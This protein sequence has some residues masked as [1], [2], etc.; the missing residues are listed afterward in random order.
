[1]TDT[2]NL[3]VPPGAVIHGD[4]FTGGQHIYNYF[5]Q[6]L[7]SLPTHLDVNAR[8]RKFLEY[9][10]GT[11][12]APAPFGGRAADLAALDDWLSDP[13]APPYALLAAPAGRGKSGL[14][15]HWV[16]RLRLR[17]A[18]GG[19]PRHIVFFPISLRFNTNAENV[20]F[21]GLAARLA[22][23]YGETLGDARDVLQFRGLFSE[24]LRRRP[25]DGLPVLVVVDGLDEAAGWEALRD[26]FPYSPPP[27][28][29]VLAAARLLAG[30]PQGEGWLARLGWEA[31][32]RAGRLALSALD[33]AGVADVLANLG[34]PLRSLAANYDLIT[35]LCQLSEGDPLLVRLY[36][37]ALL[38][39]QGQAAAFTPA[40]LETLEPGLDAYFTRWFDEQRA[41]SGADPRQDKRVRGLLNLC[42][43]ALGPLQRADLLELAAD[44]FD[45]SWTIDEAARAVNRFVL[46]DGEATGYAFSHPRLDDYF[47]ERL[48]ARERRAW[49]G[50][51]LDYG[52]R[53][54]AA[55]QAGELPAAE[56]SPYLLQFYSAHLDP[57]PEAPPDPAT[58]DLLSE[59]WLRA[60]EA[61]T[62]SPTG[63]LADARRAWRRA[64]A[65]GPAGLPQQ[66]RAALCLA[67]VTSPA[68]SLSVSL[69]R[70]CV[71]TGVISFTLGLATARHKSSPLDRAQA[72]A[73]LLP[74]APAPE[75]A[76]VIS[77]LLAAWQAVDLHPQAF[78]SLE[79]LSNHLPTDPAL[80][81]A[82]TAAA[83]TGQLDEAH[84]HRLASDLADM[85]PPRPPTDS[86]RPPNL[87]AIR[88]GPGEMLRANSLL[89]AIPR[90]PAVQLPEALELARQIAIQPAR[91][92]AIVA[93]ARRLP[94]A[95]R[96]GLLRATLAEATSLDDARQQ[97][98]LLGRIVAQYAGPDA[99]PPA[100][101]ERVTQ[102]LGEI[103][104]HLGS[105]GAWLAF[106]AA[107]PADWPQRSL[108][109]AEG[110]RQAEAITD[111]EQRA[112]LLVTSAEAMPAHAPSQ[113]ELLAQSLEA[114]N[115]VA[116]ARDRLV[117]LV[118]LAP[119]L[120]QAQR[121]ACLDAALEIANRLRTDADWP[122]W[123][124]KIAAASATDT[125][126]PSSNL[127]EAALDVL[128]QER[129]AW[130][131]A[132]TV[133]T[134][135][136]HLPA[137]YLDEVLGV[138]ALA[139]GD[140][141]SATWHVNSLC[142]I[143][144]RLPH[145]QASPVISNALD[146]ANSLGPEDRAHAF[147]NIAAIMSPAHE[148]RLSLATDALRLSRET[149]TPATTAEIVDRL[150]V[151]LP[152]SLLG[153]AL[154]LSWSA[155]NHLRP[156]TLSVLAN[157][158]PAAAQALS[159]SEIAA[160]TATLKAFGLVHRWRLLDALNVLLPVFVRLGGRS[161]LS[162]VADAVLDAGRWWT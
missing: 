43:V 118:H 61:V 52:R 115:R 48:T 7:D 56:A 107:L 9:Y 44:Y 120:P 90:L 41:L 154:S 158:W 50:R 63:F 39:H 59:A 150:A 68:E 82:L 77:D 17:Q 96:L 22:H 106:A 46:G 55:L 75:L 117:L 136:P 145:D 104:D 47:A 36:V 8:V 11:R 141:G 153:E 155:P 19:P 10:V 87:A 86:A 147:A 128:R 31:P 79:F 146:V 161:V 94:H 72:L 143:A 24:Y 132:Y 98:S 2:G 121:G 67:S 112:W 138:L 27:H 6:G 151:W 110:Q 76:G 85:K 116:D 156:E 20:V 5:I 83:E 148:R 126:P 23:V 119:W 57:D 92:D 64:E 129:S 100:L 102:R 157:R 16:T 51:F 35:K 12:E 1:M 152:D 28:L 38:P 65:D 25:P 139:A 71:E 114:A 33:R 37:E 40:D 149:S 4:V 45:D 26:L 93:I 78:S 108:A 133:A 80:Q 13:A 105:A 91:D 89:A 18:E 32:G 21:V 15:A 111:P 42:A 130:I 74:F 84:R 60:H 29:R 135:V 69:L 3:H 103:S 54:L 131:R 70:A 62:G 122:Q 109:L 123:A 58:L 127:I 159:L 134:I 160:L 137:S 97:G 140:M 142:A 144:A 125:Q 53:A 34:N 124:I 73:G 95:N 88:N 49:Q 101:M 162:G 14:L 66:V 30:D 113:T 99:N 81:A